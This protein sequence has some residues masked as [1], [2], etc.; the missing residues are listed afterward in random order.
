[1]N[2]PH[3]ICVSADGQQ[4]VIGDTENHRVRQVTLGP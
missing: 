1:L 3:G 4:V 2:R